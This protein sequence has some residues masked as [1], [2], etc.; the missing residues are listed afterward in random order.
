ML[1]IV[2]QFKMAM[3]QFLLPNL[4]T[5]LF[6]HPQVYLTMEYTDFPQPFEDL[7]RVA[8]KKHYLP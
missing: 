8:K 6:C 7:G 3:I 5:M 2:L 4:Q 1:S